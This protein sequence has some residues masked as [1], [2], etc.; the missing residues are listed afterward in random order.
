MLGFYYSPE[1][2]VVSLVLLNR[3]LALLVI[4]VAAWFII[5][6][7]QDRKMLKEREADKFNV[8]LEST[9]DGMA[10]VNSHGQIETANEQLEKLS[11][12]PQMEL[13]GQQIEVLLPERYKDHQHLRENYYAGPY[14]RQIGVG[15]ELFLRRKNGTEFQAEIALSPLEIDERS[16]VIAA[17]PR[18]YRS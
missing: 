14:I 15:Q 4:W 1:G 7:K 2:G 13:V 11:G 16:I 5:K 18:Y 17:Y 3:V 6:Q 12:Y 8:L 10:I 9:H